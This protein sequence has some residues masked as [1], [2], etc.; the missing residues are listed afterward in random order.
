MLMPNLSV[1][2][3]DLPAPGTNKIALVDSLLDKAHEMAAAVN[4]EQSLRLSLE[5]LDESTS[6]N[7]NRGLVR[8]V[9][10]TSQALFNAGL[11]DES[12]KYILLVDNIENGEG[13]ELYRSQ[14]CKIRGQIYSYLKMH[15]H[16]Q[17]AFDEG[18]VEADKLENS[19]H[20]DYLKS[21]L[22]ESKAV[23][24]F[25]TKRYDLQ[26]EYL[27]KSI[28]LLESMDE[29]S[30]YT[31]KVNSYTLMGEYYLLNERPEKALTYFDKAYELL[32]KY[33]FLYRSRLLKGMAEVELALS[34]PNNALIYLYEAIENVS[35]TNITPDLPS[36]YKT[37]A[38]A[39]AMID[40]TDS[41]RYY[42]SLRN[43][44][45]YTIS[46]SKINSTSLAMQK[47]LDEHSRNSSSSNSITLE[48][49]TSI[50]VLLLL[51]GLTFVALRILKSRMLRNKKQELKAMQKSLSNAIDE[52]SALA[53]S[54]APTFIIRFQEVYPEFWKKLNSLHPDLSPAELKLCAMTYLGFTTSEIAAAEF[55]QHGSVQTRRARMRKKIN[56]DGSVDLKEYL[57][58]IVDG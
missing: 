22:Y 6:I 42:Q 52:V 57:T 16:A 28:K 15:S 20:R 3:T 25:T 11:Y 31:L 35:L 17:K 2:S 51:V 58:S 12:L 29:K 26:Y 21:M 1:A 30:V 54:N 18:I 36:L 46:Q 4:I 48:L 34:R 44:V 41:V 40:N 56:L 37:M 50:V 33:N 24:Y 9:Y 19:H 23:D 43:E 49:I 39:Y 38:E 13:Q 45:D 55:V 10:S 32:E 27:S 7:Y 53:K 8:A 47:I 14:I 5:A